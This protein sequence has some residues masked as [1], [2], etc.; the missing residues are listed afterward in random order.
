MKHLV[1]E[2]SV[3]RGSLLLELGEDTGLVGVDPFRG[4]AF[5][6]A[7]TVTV[8]LPER[9]NFIFVNTFDLIANFK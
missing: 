8:S 9:N 1:A 3:A 5:H 2:D 6:D 4:H 7:V